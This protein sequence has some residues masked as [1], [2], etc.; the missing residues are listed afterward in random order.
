MT[1]APDI[2]PLARRIARLGVPWTPPKDTE[3]PCREDGRWTSDVED[4]WRDAQLICGSC[5]WRVTCYETALKQ[6]DPVGVRGGVRFGGMGRPV[7]PPQ[8]RRHAL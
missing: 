4:E 1:G 8:E 3:T 7:P 5:E 6:S 2:Q